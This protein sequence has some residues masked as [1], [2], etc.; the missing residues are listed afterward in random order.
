[1]LE[2]G[3]DHVPGRPQQVAVTVGNGENGS[4]ALQI[5]RRQHDRPLLG[6]G[7]EGGGGQGRAHRHHLMAVVAAFPVIALA[8]AVSAPGVSAGSALV[9]RGGRHQLGA[10]RGLE[11]AERVVGRQ[12]GLAHSR[13]EGVPAQQRQEGLKGLCH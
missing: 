10:G 12:R 2:G 3:E 1:M 6:A 11:H 9:V 5:F 13:Y 7:R 4:H 8:A